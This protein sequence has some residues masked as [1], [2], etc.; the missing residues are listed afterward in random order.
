MKTLEFYSWGF[1]PV[2]RG[3]TCWA[4]EVNRDGWILFKNLIIAAVLMTHYL[5]CPV[6]L[7]LFSSDK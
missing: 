6:I 4:E 5:A 7:L 1:F 2:Y 3:G